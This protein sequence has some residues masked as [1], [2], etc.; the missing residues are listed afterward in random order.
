MAGADGAGINECTEPA[1]L[2]DQPATLPG[3]QGLELE[4]GALEVGA[5]GTAALQACLG[6]DRLCFGGLWSPQQ[7]ANELADPQRPGLGLWQGGR[8]M[9]MA[10]AWL[11]VDELH[12]TLVAVDPCCRR[13]GLA[14]DLLRELLQRGRE[15][16]A[17]RA[18][19]EVGSNNAAAQ[20]VYRSLGFQTVGVRRKYYSNGEDALIQ[21][22]DL[23]DVP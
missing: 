18:T 14:K 7:W 10:C 15:L 12:I 13:R 21:W 5:L 23:A 6:L 4:V 11:I 9:A 1:A 19:L 20:A 3:S 22:F 16:G 17:A 2:T 8:L